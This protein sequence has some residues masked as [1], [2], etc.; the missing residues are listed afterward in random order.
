MCASATPLGG[1]VATFM[2]S[3]FDPTFFPDI[4]GL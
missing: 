3:C 2:E 1:T 4:P